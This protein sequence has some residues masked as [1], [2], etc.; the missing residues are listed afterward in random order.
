M[1]RTNAETSISVW[2][3]FYCFVYIILESIKVREQRSPWT[4][5]ANAQ[6]VSGLHWSL[7]IKKLEFPWSEVFRILSV[8]WNTRLLKFANV[9]LSHCNKYSLIIGLNL[10][11]RVWGCLWTPFWWNRQK[12]VSNCKGLFIYLFYLSQCMLWSYGLANRQFQK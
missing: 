5:C 3:G 6:A 9:Q 8:C 4:D 7:I 11:R 1:R 12:R 10:Q 2:S